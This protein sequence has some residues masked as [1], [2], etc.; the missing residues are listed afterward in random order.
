MEC[1]NISAILAILDINSA[2]EVTIFACFL[3]RSLILY[4]LSPEVPSF[5]YY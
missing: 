5:V 2:V 3:T 1:K 4:P